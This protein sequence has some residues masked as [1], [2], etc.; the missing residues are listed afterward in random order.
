MLFGKACISSIIIVTDTRAE[1]F[2]PAI[3]A[4]HHT[5]ILTYSCFS[6]NE[7]KQIFL[8]NLHTVK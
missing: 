4:Q 2:P 7:F 1:F 8:R 6:P 3:D 5:D